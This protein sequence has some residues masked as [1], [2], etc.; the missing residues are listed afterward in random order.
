MNKMYFYSNVGHKDEY[1]S[2]RMSY[3]SF[4]PALKDY[5]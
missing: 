1:N 2:N 3:H 4:Y 5:L